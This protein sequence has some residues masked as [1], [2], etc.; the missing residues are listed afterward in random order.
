[1]KATTPLKKWKFKGWRWTLIF[2]CFDYSFRYCGLK[3]LKK[4][5]KDDDEDQEVKV[6]NQGVAKGPGTLGDSKLAPTSQSLEVVGGNVRETTVVE[7]GARKSNF[8]A[9]RPRDLRFIQVWIL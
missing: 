6:L 3:V 5:T 4:V 9:V 7:V 1:M 8:V 2:K